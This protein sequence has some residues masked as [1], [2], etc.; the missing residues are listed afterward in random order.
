MVFTYAI[1]TPASPDPD[2][3]G[4]CRTRVRCP[5][6]KGRAGGRGGAE[7]GERRETKKTGVRLTCRSPAGPRDPAR[8]PMPLP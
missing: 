1:P 3:A 8:C 7:D 6:G 4:V 2:D 5:N